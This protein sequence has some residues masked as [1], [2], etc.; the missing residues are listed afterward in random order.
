MSAFNQYAQLDAALLVAIG[1][2]EVTFAKIFSLVSLQVDEEHGRG[3]STFRMVDRRLHAL[4]EKGL[5]KFTK[6]AGVGSWV[7]MLRNE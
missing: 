7:K 3:K 1:T 4:K 6:Y 5:V 2:E